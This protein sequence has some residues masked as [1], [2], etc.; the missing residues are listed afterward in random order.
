MPS[1]AASVN[2]R[3][4]STGRPPIGKAA[5]AMLTLPAAKTKTLASLRY[6]T[7]AD[8]AADLDIIGH[9]QGETMIAED[10]ADRRAMMEMSRWAIDARA[11]RHTEAN[12]IRLADKLIVS[13]PADATPQHHREMVAGI[14]SD[15]GGDSDAWLVAAIHRDRGGNPHAHVLAIDGLET[16]AAALARRP[17]AKRVR[18]RDALRLNEGGNRQELRQRIAAQINRVSDAHGYRRAEVRS[19]VAQGVQRAAQEHE[20]PVGSA[21]R[22]YRECEEWMDQANA[23]DGPGGSLQEIEAVFPALKAPAK[24]RG[25]SLFVRG[26]AAQKATAQAEDDP[27]RE[28]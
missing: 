28:R 23:L 17:D 24:G 21:R 18:R 4:I 11:V 16:R 2:V 8:A 14:V 20:G 7:R 27:G 22:T 25:P 3:H 15:L 10:A 26:R 1:Y 13:L 9:N 19:L 6:I 12:G 5:R